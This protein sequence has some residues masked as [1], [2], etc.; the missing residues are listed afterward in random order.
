MPI[1]GWVIFAGTAWYTGYRITRYAA[2]PPLPHNVLL[3]RVPRLIFALCGFPQASG[4][5]LG[6][7]YVASMWLQITGG[8]FLAY[9]LIMEQYRAVVSPVLATLM[10]LPGGFLLG[11]LFAFGLYPSWRFLDVPRIPRD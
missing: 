5:P 3:V 7:V 4:L 9:G 11:A 1:I 6:V 8:F 2:P 10:G